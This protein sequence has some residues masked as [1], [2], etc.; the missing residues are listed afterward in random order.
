MNDMPR[1]FFKPD[2]YRRRNN[3][4]NNKLKHLNNSDLKT[5]FQIPSKKT[6]GNVV[7][8]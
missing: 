1:D 5:K 7:V 3:L 8:Q 2:F 4:I 6:M